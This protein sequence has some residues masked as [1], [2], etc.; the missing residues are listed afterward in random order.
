[1]NLETENILSNYNVLDHSHEKA[2]NT[3]VVNWLLG[4]LCNFSCS[5]CP[6]FL[7]SGSIEWPKLEKLKKFILDIDNHFYNKQIYFEFTG[8]EV[9][10]YP[11]LIDL[12][13]FIHS[14]GH[15][16]GIISNGTRHHNWW[17]KQKDK[18]DHICFSYH[19]EHTKPKKFFNVVKTVAG[20]FRTHVNIMMNP[21]KWQDCITVA[22]KVTNECQNV[23]LALQPLMQGLGAEETVFPYTTEQQE[24]LDKQH[25]IYGSKIK[26]TKEFKVPRGA[27]KMIETVSNKSEIS[28]AH[29]LISNKMN[30]WSGWKCYAG[31]ENLVI[32][33][34]GTILRGWC[35]VGSKIGNVYTDY[36]LPTKPVLCNKKFCHCNFDIMCKKEKINENY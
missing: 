26:W 16:V 28:S 6:E 12:C 21:D 14:L 24:I 25:H 1:M 33:W 30:N 29:R 35:R 20:E 15:T 4:N 27:M 2:K 3:V 5:Y 22:E 9:T 19:A 7:H 13:D 23:S 31:L 11:E 8:G 10:L 32:D 18:F 17:Y 36:V 34:D